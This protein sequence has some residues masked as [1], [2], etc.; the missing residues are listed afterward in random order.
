M[1]INTGICVFVEGLFDDG[2]KISKQT[3]SSSSFVWEV[4]N[5]LLVSHGSQ[6]N[7]SKRDRETKV[8]YKSKKQ[9]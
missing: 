5:L 7:W 1:R 8:K 2:T 6:E 9:K 3:N 4:R